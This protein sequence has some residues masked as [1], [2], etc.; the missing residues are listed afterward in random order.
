[1][2]RKLLLWEAESLMGGERYVEG[3]RNPTSALLTMP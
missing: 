2:Q 3:V 1:M